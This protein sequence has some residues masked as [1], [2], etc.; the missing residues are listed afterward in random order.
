MVLGIWLAVIGSPGAAVAKIVIDADVE[1][2]G[3]WSTFTQLVFSAN[4]TY[5]SPAFVEGTVA[6]DMNHSPSPG[7]SVTRTFTGIPLQPGTYTVEFA[8]GNQTNAPFPPS[9]D[10][11]FA[12][13]DLSEA[14]SASTPTPASGDWELWQIV[15]EVERCHPGLGNDITFELAITTG[16]TSNLRFDGVGS[17]SSSG[18]G[19]VVD[20]APALTGDYVLYGQSYLDFNGDTSTVNAIS[21]VA[22]IDESTPGSPVLTQLDVDVCWSQ[23][24]DATAV[25]GCA[26]STVNLDSKQ[27]LRPTPGQVGT[28]STVTSIS[29]GTLTGW[30]QTGH[31]ACTTSP[32]PSCPSCSACVPFFGYEGTGPPLPLSSSSYDTDPWSFIPL[33]NPGILFVTDDFQI[34]NLAA[35]AVT[36]AIRLV[37]VRSTVLQLG[38]GTFCVLGVPTGTD[39]SWELNDTWGASV[40]NTAVTDVDLASDFADSITA[41]TPA[42]IT[43]APLAAVP[44]CFSVSGA[45]TPVKLEVG[46]SPGPVDC[47]VSLAG[48][49]FNPVIVPLPLVF[50]VPA[51]PAWAIL[52]VGLV[53]VA[54]GVRV[55]RRSAAR[56]SSGDGS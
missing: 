42:A 38:L 28:G 48:C 53:L 15:W 35:G 41:I 37:G 52:G 16:V 4:P 36:Q 9:I 34:T 29:W 2:D 11:E 22:S 26:G 50:D 33:G 12:G 13:M 31:L 6:A 43:A 7:D 25:C 5:L 8:I 32:G 1:D 46:P 39:W 44:Q 49:T 24:F 47:T 3:D 23:S 10:I 30:T 55:A 14:S 51:A 40:T 45:A 18:D 54:L 27:L 17:L 56:S 20:Y 19:F 21:G